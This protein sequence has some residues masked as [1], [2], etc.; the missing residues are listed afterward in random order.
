M[1][2][3]DSARLDAENFANKAEQTIRI[4]RTAAHPPLLLIVFRHFDQ[5]PHHT[6]S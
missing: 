3:K 1:Q 4:I 2:L 5:T 6:V